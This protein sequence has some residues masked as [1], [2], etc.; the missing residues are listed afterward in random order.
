[1]ANANIQ[2][3]VSSLFK[4]FLTTFKL[5][6]QDPPYFEGQLEEMKRKEASTIFVDFQW[7]Q[8]ANQNLSEVILMSYYRFEKALNQAKEGRT[9]V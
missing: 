9:S 8:Q 6:E 3:E 4:Q 7:V 2:Q 5:R 1:M